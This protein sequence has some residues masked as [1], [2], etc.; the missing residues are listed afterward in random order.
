MKE[1]PNELP[2]I[3]AQFEYDGT[4]EYAN[5]LLDEMLRHYTLNQIAAHCG[6]S[7]R[8]LSYMRHGGIKNYPVQITLE[9][10][11]GRKRLDDDDRLSRSL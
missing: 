7:R 3:D 9:I 11:A 4:P 2:Q 6:I 8:N 1:L 10:M 5:E